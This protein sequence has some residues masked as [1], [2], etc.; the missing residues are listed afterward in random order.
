MSWDNRN[1]WHMDHKKPISA[2]SKNTS[3]KIINMLSNLRPI[4][5]TENLSKGNKF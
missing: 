1:E 3:P 5:A 4:W 2:F